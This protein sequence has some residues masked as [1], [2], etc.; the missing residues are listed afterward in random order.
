M[1]PDQ[2]DN[3]KKSENFTMRIIYRDYVIQPSHVP[4]EEI[5]R[6]SVNCQ[7]LLSKQW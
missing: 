2:K 5:D 3:K 6:N 4:D 1:I 7:V